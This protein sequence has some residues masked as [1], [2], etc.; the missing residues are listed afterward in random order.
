M[1]KTLKK[2][3]RAGQSAR[4]KTRGRGFAGAEENSAERDGEVFK[5]PGRARIMAS[6]RE[7]AR[8]LAA[9]M[10][11]DLIEIQYRR[12]SGRMV[13]RLFLDRGPNDGP[14]GE[15]EAEPSG[16]GGVTL[17][18]LA[19]LNRELGLLLDLA[20][21]LPGRY[22][23]EVSSP[24]LDRLLNY[25]D[26]FRRYQNRPASLRLRAEDGS[27][28]SLKGIL[29][30]LNAQGDIIFQPEEARPGEGPV[31]VP[32]ARLISARLTPRINWRSGAE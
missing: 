16:P 28:R 18:E 1:P 9:E 20:D 4:L 8:P 13:L 17:D 21:I 27:R 25:P 29:K 12:E 11:L 23:L 31:L 7:M 3:G 32:S 24:G 15:A 6:V 10:N 2:D 14:A 26:D 22:T 30:G 5:S 19:R